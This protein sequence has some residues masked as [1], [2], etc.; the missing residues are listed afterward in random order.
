MQVKV[1]DYGLIV[2]IG[3]S[4]SGKSSFA[5]RFFR[6]T[7]ILESDHYRGIVGDDDRSRRTTKDAFDVMDEVAARRLN[8]R[9]LTVIDATNL[10]RDNRRRYIELS[11][12]HHAP[13]TAIVF[14][15]PEKH[16]QAQNEKRGNKA[17]P[18]HVV[19]RHCR[20][21]KQSLKTLSKEGYRRRYRM[22]TA[23]EIDTATMER[24]PLS[25]DVR[26]RPGPF[27]IIGDVHG[28]L[29]ELRSMLEKL[30]Y[31][32]IEPA[33]PDSQY[34]ITPPNGRT[35]IFVGDLVD[36]GPDSGGVLDLVRAMAASGAALVVA[37]N[38]DWKLARALKGRPVE[39]KHG[40]AET[41]AELET[42]TAEERAKVSDF[43]QALPSHYVLDNG[44]LV[45][46]HAGMKEELQNR[47]SSDV[48]DFSLYGE[49]T[50]ETDADGL[51]VRLDW[52]QEYRGSATVIYGHT[53]VRSTEWVNETLCIDT[54]CAFGGRLT[55]LQ[56][57]ERNLIDV[58]AART[59][60]EPPKT[61]T[62]E[63]ER[64]HQNAQQAN[65]KL[66][67]VEDVSGQL[68]V[69][70]SL[71]GTVK[72]RPQNSAAA[73]EAM[74]RFALDPRWLIYL[75]PTM[76]PAPTS[77][78]DGLLEH[79]AE[80]FDYYQARATSLLICE[81]KHMGS[82]AIFVIARSRE[83]AL[84]RFGITNDAA[85]VAYTRTGRRF[86]NNPEMEHAVIDRLR[87]AIAKT[88]GW[89]W[90]CID[91][92]IMP[93]SAKGADLIATHYAP[94]AAAAKM[95]LAQ[96]TRYLTQAQERDP[97]HAE[98]LARYQ[99]KERMAEAYDRAYQHYSWPVN[100]VDDL[101]VAPFHVL[102]NEHGVH[103]NK[104]HM[105]HLE[106]IDA[107][108][109]SE[110]IVART[111]RMLV[112]TTHANEREHATRWW[113]QRTAAGAEGMV[114]KPLDFT[115]REKDR[116]VAPALKCRG[117]EYL[118]VIYGP[119]YN[120]PEQLDRLRRRSNGGKLRLSLQ[121][122]ALGIEALQL[123]CDRQ[124]LRKVH[125]A[126]FGVLALESEPVDPRL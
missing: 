16:C 121:E 30:N 79:P 106:Q 57:P 120:A 110:P 11:R 13:L 71:V 29:S 60:V 9:R 56:W 93:W 59:Y 97:A 53:P 117:R 87:N 124:P 52:A 27:D 100:S 101:K 109:K 38:H 82:R 66:L 75:P 125:R 103:A 114:V 48:R 113:E 126:V 1:P 115:A 40:L 111:E 92:E 45:V 69:T 80:A 64:A 34:R 74:S 25:C 19:R 50:G 122:F 91:A 17:S 26:N 39:R 123:F 31:Q 24:E 15:L 77:Q 47:S 3:A 10:E 105:W 90:A 46:A 83:A 68:N 118:R 78:K 23:D 94:V 35:A 85:G 84:H 119:E 42:R 76:A 102:A 2:L 22:R 21:V 95:G 8:A 98:L 5:K 44:R 62:A 96:A 7:E 36:R 107:L 63:G 70:T 65:D 67:D 14:D 49:T 73:L 81:E 58:P 43:I 6:P 54:G 51:P 32:V 104:S 28:C 61:M 55:A 89:E 20:A 112:D 18:P 86:F 4:G 108:A 41:M 88:H 12:A 99:S 72:V 116:L 37:G 33:G